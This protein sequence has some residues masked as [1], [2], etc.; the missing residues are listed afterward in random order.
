MLLI[1][2]SRSYIYTKD[3]I[4]IF[5]SVYLGKHTNYTNS[6]IFSKKQKQKQKT[7]RTLEAIKLTLLQRDAAV[8]GQLKKEIV[9]WLN[10][11]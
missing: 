3:L 2:S 7:K 10:L 4:I 6:T 9:L 1:C 8:S 5:C 11:A